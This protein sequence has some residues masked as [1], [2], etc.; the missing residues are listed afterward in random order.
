[1][2][3]KKVQKRNILIAVD[4][5]ENAA[6]AVSYVRDLLS[7]LPGFRI[8]LVTIIPEPSEDYFQS[9]SERTEWMKEKKSSARS[10]LE[11]FRRLLIDA[12]FKEGDI[13]VEVA[14]KTCPSIAECILAEQENLACGAVVIGRRG[15]S[16]KEEFIFGSTSSKILH[17]AK[18]CAVW[19]IE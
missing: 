19:V 2:E 14:I 9:E 4:E 7:G 15:I 3:S 8:N 18:D 17:T 12:G 5:S 10:I 16:K 13:R 1:M 6:R 11:G